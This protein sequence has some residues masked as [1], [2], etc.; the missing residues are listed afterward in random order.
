MMTVGKETFTFDEWVP[1]IVKSPDQAWTSCTCWAIL[2]PN[3]CVPI[4]LGGPFLVINSIVID[5][6]LHT[7]I[8]KKTG[9]DLFHLPAIKCNVIKPKPIFG[10]ELKKLQKSVIVDITGL[11]PN[12]K[13]IL[14][15]VVDSYK[16][17]PIAA[18]HTYIE[19]LV[20]DLFEGQRF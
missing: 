10:P 1:V 18:I 7:C 4:L 12:T 6:K 13:D 14:D 3:L 8:D 19:H 20:S 16:P 9:F 11:F 17:C 15:V 2:V 5:H